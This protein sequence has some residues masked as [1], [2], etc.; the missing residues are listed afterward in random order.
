MLI[1]L[2]G[3]RYDRSD[4]TALLYS[5]FFIIICIF[6]IT[7]FREAAKKVLHLWPLFYGYFTARLIFCVFPSEI[8]VAERGL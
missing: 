4:M 1:R 3:G 7:L 8:M 5:D 6:S 2:R